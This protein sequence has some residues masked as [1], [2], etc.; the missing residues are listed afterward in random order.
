MQ[1]CVSFQGLVLIP[2]YYLQRVGETLL[3]LGH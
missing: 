1:F 3:I 2:Y